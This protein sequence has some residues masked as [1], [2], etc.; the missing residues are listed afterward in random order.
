MLAFESAFYRGNLLLVEV[1]IA[2]VD[3]APIA[4]SLR[5]M[6]RVKVLVCTIFGSCVDLKPFVVPSIDR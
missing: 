2:V 4:Q 3:V 6:L 5:A 1:I